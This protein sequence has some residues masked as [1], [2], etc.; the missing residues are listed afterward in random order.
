MG[1]KLT[2]NELMAV[3]IA[4]SLVVNLL[5]F[6]VRWRDRRRMGRLLDGMR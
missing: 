1:T 6:Y 5:P 3:A 4:V 2:L